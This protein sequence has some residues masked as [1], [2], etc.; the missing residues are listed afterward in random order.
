M[1]KTLTCS[2]QERHA[3][4]FKNGIP[5]VVFLLNHMHARIHYAYTG[6]KGLPVHGVGTDASWELPAGV[7]TVAMRVARHANEY[8]T[9]VL[10]A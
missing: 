4:P 5:D 1:H 8:I 7:A 9:P 3:I 2:Y 10:K 6:T